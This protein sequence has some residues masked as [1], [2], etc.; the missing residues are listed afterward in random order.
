MVARRS[1]GNQ[2]AGEGKRCATK[3]DQGSGPKLG[4]CHVYGL[5]DLLN[6]GR[7]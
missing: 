5:A 6:S 3:T 1:A 7:D 2:V 4:N